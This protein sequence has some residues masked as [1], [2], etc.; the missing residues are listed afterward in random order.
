MRASGPYLARSLLAAAMALAAG[1]RTARATPA[2]LFGAGPRSTALA[3]AGVSLEMGPEAALTNP[4]LLAAATKELDIG[5]RATRFALSIEASGRSEPFPAELSKSL[6]FGVSAPLVDGPLALGFGLFAQTPP[7]FVVRARVPL[8]GV[9]TFPL[10]VGR[11]DALDLGAGLGARIGPLGVGVGV[12]A[13]AALAGRVA[14]TEEQGHTASSVSTRLLPSV[15]PVLGATL[16]VEPVGRLGFALRGPLRADFDVDVAAASLGGLGIVPLHVQG[17]AAY[18]PLRIDLELSR[19]IGAVTAVVGARFEHFSA[20]PG[21]AGPTVECPPADRRCGTP[22]G[23]PPGYHDVVSP[24]V[25]AT[26][27]T[28][29]LAPA[30]LE[31][32]AGYTL[33]PTP[34]PEQTGRSNVFDATRHGLAFGYSITL[35]PALAPLRLDTAFRFDLLAPRRHDKLPEAGGGSITTHGHTETLL[36]GAGVEL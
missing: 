8:E 32:R 20:F 26:L 29:W 13:L 27:A 2:E 6:C 11:A 31:L 5:L 17:V 28:G 33:A 18:E 34:I 1:P 16:D 23:E 9:P 21:W 14:V 19:A 25:G 15:A 7:G 30:T 36:V 10:L 35:P 3:G 4:A 12:R 24:R 22:P